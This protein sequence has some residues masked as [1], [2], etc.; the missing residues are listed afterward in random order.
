MD[1]ALLISTGP[2]DTLETSTAQPN[3]DA[4]K[5]KH[6][7]LAVMFRLGMKQLFHP[8]FVV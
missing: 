1:V 7:D 8:S 4:K 2:S 6:V 5:V 3:K